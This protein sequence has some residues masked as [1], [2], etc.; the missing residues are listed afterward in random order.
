MPS[1]YKFSPNLQRQRHVI[2][3]N[4]GISQL[5]VRSYGYSHIFYCYTAPFFLNRFFFD[6]QSL[7]APPRISAD[8]RGRN[9]PLTRSRQSF[10]SNTRPTTRC[11]PT[12]FGPIV[13]SRWFF[14]QLSSCSRFS[15]Q[16]A[17]P[18][19]SHPRSI[20]NNG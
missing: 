12:Y 6:K 16:L 2:P 1:Q 13:G 9:H 5:V 11:Q 20:S 7:L 17:L 14:C 8:L 19:S 4:S 15:C 3:A 18:G 10:P